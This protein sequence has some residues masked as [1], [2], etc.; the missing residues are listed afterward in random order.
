[1]NALLSIKP[2]YV[3]AIV[4]GSKRY[5]FRKSIFTAKIIEKVY[6]YSTAPVKRIVGA[7]GLRRIIED[8]PK[9]LWN[10]LHKFSG[11]NDAE[12]FSYFSGAERGFAIEID[13]V[14]EFENPIDPRDLV[15][16]FVPPQS[17]CYV[18]SCILLFLLRERLSI[19]CF[20]PPSPSFAVR[21]VW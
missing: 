21:R 10:Q 20:T 9:Q 13:S 11:L 12:F 15:P 4:G 8:H 1:M 14:E 7:F 5:E 16:S 18:D 3:E 19:S 6:I 17:F 2:K